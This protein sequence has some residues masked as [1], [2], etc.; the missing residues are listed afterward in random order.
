MLVSAR[1]DLPVL[2]PDEVSNDSRSHIGMEGMPQ[3]CE[4]T[5]RRR[6]NKRFHISRA[7]ELLQGGGDALREAML[8]EVMPV[9]I[10]H[11]AAEVRRRTFECAS[12]AP[13][14]LKRV[15]PSRSGFSSQP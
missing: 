4:R 1:P 15:S 11:A 14:R 8:L 5:R 3:V 2:Q 9:D 12:R 13:S 7:H 10:L 6:D